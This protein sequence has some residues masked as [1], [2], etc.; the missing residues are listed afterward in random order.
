MLL[1]ATRQLQSSMRTP[2]VLPERQNY[3][4]KNRSAANEVHVRRTVCC[5]SSLHARLLLSLTLSY[6]LMLSLTLS[7]SPTL[8]LTLSLSLPLTHTLSLSLSLSL[9]HSFTLSFFHSFSLSLF[10]S[11]SL[12]LF[13]SFSLSLTNCSL[14]PV[15]TNYRNCQRALMTPKHAP[16]SLPL[17]PARCGARFGASGGQPRAICLRTGF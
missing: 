5:C 13:H 17:H 14:L 11:L 6:S 3:S 12:S 16:R 15:R 7:H 10:L 2:R 1:K 9:S 4:E 8:S